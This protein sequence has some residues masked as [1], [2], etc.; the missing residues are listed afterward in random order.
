[1]AKVGHVPHSHSHFTSASQW[2]VGEMYPDDPSQGV[3][4]ELGDEAPWRL[5]AVSESLF[6]IW[7]SA[8]CFRVISRCIICAANFIYLSTIPFSKTCDFSLILSRTDPHLA[9]VAKN[10]TDNIQKGA[11]RKCITPWSATVLIQI[12]GI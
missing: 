4:G 3:V 11:T 9:W 10:Y 6:V 2:G 1:M 12:S 5:T 8:V 7:A